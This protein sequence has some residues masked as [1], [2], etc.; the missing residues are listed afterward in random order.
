MPPLSSSVRQ[1]QAGEGSST[2]ATLALSG[3]Q[4]MEVCG[5]EVGWGEEAEEAGGG[6]RHH[7]MSSIGNK[8]D[9]MCLKVGVEEGDESL[10]PSSRSPPVRKAR[11]AGV[12]FA[13][14]PIIMG[15]ADPDYDRRSIRV[16]LSKTPYVLFRKDAYFMKHPEEY[17]PSPKSPQRNGCQQWS[18]DEEEAMTEGELESESDEDCSITTA[19]LGREKG[20]LP[21]RPNFSGIWKRY[22]VDGFVELLMFSGIPERA[23]RVAAQRAPFHI[24][25]HDDDYCRIIIKNGLVKAD[26]HYI[27]G[28]EPRTEHAGAHDYEVSMEWADGTGDGNADSLVLVSLSETAGT[29]MIA[30]RSLEEKGECLVLQ[31]IVRRPKT[32]EETRARHVFRRVKDKND[33]VISKPP[34]RRIMLR[35]NMSAD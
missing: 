31:Q 13:E 19:G 23:A 9:S 1:L 33:L 24:I 5:V 18:S 26:N 7:R 14:E 3:Q 20:L 10:S 15:T 30:I 11:P 12:T 29:E 16:D 25:D 6:A 17:A 21:A 28:D 35:T 27:I 34:Q 8:R 22:K 32:G 4:P 2:E